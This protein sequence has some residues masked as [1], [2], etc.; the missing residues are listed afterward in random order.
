[1]HSR[2]ALLYVPGDDR[3]KIEKALTFGVDSICLDMEDGV[4]L[5]RKEAARINIPK[6]LRELDFDAAEKLV[7]INAV[8]SGLEETD[9]TAALPARP[10]GIVIPKLEAL[11]QVQWAAEIIEAAEL[12]NGWPVNSIRILVGVETARGILNLKEI[13]SHPRLEAIIFG[14]EDYA[15]NIGATRSRNGWEVLYARSAI[16]TACAAYDLQAIDMVSIDFKDV[17]NLKVEAAQGA[18]MGFSGKQVIHP[19]QVAPVQ[20]AFT[21]S[22]EAIA[23]AQQLVETFEASQREGKGAYALDGKMIDRPLLKQAEKVLARARAAGKA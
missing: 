23:H 9:L 11:E 16:V 5:N 19:A 8:G 13:A 20:E 1:M 7:R 2:R 15:A 22:D 6:A 18:A 12:S 14:A 21:P 17:V 10:D 4:A 3:N